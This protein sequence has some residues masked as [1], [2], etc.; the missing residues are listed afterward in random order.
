MLIVIALGMLFPVVWMLLLSMKNTPE[1]YSNILDLLRADFTLENYKAILI[2]DT[3][4][5]YFANSLFIAVCV[6]IGNVLFCAM[7]GYA[8]ARKKTGWGKIVFITLII[9]LMIPPHVIMIPLYRLIVNFGWM[10]SYY[11]LIFP[12]IITPFGIFMIKQYSESIPIEIEDA[13]Q[14]D[15]ANQ[16]VIFFKIV[17]PMM[18]PALFVL[19]VYTFLTNWNSFL[20]P[21]LFTN[22]IEHRTLPVALAFFMGKQSIS[23]G[24]LMAGASIS[25]IP[26]IILFLIFQKKI[27]AGLTSGAL[28]ES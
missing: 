13:A 9:V 20:F 18:K 2:N 7:A 28:K 6:T 3:F 4:S 16:W 14:I 11:S 24:S 22:D 26:V 19:A 17:L 12:W 23:W 1:Q 5:L 21:F 27:I 10:N 25:A 8:L 15:G